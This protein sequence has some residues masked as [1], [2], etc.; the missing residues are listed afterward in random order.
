M[1]TFTRLLD[2]TEIDYDAA[3]AFALAY[4]AAGLGSAEQGLVELDELVVLMAMCYQVELWWAVA[5]VEPAAAY[6]GELAA[7]AERERVRLMLAELAETYPSSRAYGRAL[8]A[9]D[10][11]AEWWFEGRR[12]VA[13]RVRG[14]RHVIDAA[15]GCSCEAASWGRKCWAVALDE[16][17]G[18]L[19]RRRMAA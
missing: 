18:R 17:L 2:V 4:E 11:G 5:V 3:V 10:D 12:L 14:S 8:E 9:L 13:Q 16:A 1:Q 7:S 15:G 6:R 19:G